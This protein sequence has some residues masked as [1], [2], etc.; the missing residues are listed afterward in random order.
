LQDQITPFC[1]KTI[2]DF[3]EEPLEKWT[4]EV[5]ED[6]ESL[7]L[8]EL[9][10]RARKAIAGSIKTVKHDLKHFKKKSHLIRKRLKDIFY[11][12]NIFE[13]DVFFTRQQVKSLDK[14]LDY[15]GSVQDH[16]VLTTNLANFRKT[17]LTGSL[18]EY[19]LVKRIELTT[20]KKKNVLLEK[21]SDMTEKLLSEAE[22]R[23]T[24]ADQQ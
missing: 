20:E 6:L 2:E 21:A 13:Q 24:V 11:W 5:R 18:Q 10:I 16:E 22:T 12:S 7:G 1:K 17:I 19:D 3:S 14:I 9:G 15:L 8:D 4:G 23:T